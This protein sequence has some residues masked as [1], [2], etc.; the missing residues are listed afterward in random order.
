MK[1]LHELVELVSNT[2][3]AVVLRIKPASRLDLICLGCF[4]GDEEMIRLTKG[5]DQTC[6]VFTTNGGHYSWHW[7][8]S[9]FT[10]VSDNLTKKGHMIQHCIEDYFDI[11]VR[12][13]KESIR[14]DMLRPED[15]EQEIVVW[16]NAAP[17]HDI[18][19]RKNGEFFRYF[20]TFDEC[21]NHF[22]ALG[23]TVK[24]TA[25]A[26]HYLLCR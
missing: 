8:R 18:G 4:N 23:Y 3:D 10:L 7:G 25:Q 6:T 22:K 15:A 14:N 2:E 17:G 16:S 5:Q 26:G 24:N 11:M 20:D 1:K 13:S 19:C 12:G 9:G 21:M